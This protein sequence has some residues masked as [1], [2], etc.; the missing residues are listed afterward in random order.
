MTW[1]TFERKRTGET[2]H[3]H[4]AFGT[5]HLL[6]N[7]PIWQPKEEHAAM[8][9]KFVGGGLL[10]ELCF[11]FVVFAL[12]CGIHALKPLVFLFEMLQLIAKQ[13]KPLL[14]D[15]STAMFSDKLVQTVDKAH[16]VTDPVG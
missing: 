5:V 14:Q 4:F 16:A 6:F 8:L 13:K 3:R 12:K 9:Y 15:G 2:G 11:Q 10:I 7:L 1:F